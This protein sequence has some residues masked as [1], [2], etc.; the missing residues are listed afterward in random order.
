[1]FCRS[2]MFHVSRF[3]N[4][5]VWILKLL[6]NDTRRYSLS[7]SSEP[8]LKKK[9]IPCVS[10]SLA[11]T[12]LLDSSNKILVLNIHRLMNLY[13]FQSLRGRGHT[14]VVWCLDSFGAINY[15]M[16]N[17][18]CEEE[19]M[20]R[21]LKQQSDESETQKL[22]FMCFVNRIVNMQ[23]D[24]NYDLFWA[25]HSQPSKHLILWLIIL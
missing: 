6:V 12:L 18:W 24:I 17:L 14:D 25:D 20:S 13:L 2:S 3:I 8:L 11:Q 5:E 7:K 22:N 10:C 15:K 9:E 16:H 23:H 4:T 1:M 19:K 21:R